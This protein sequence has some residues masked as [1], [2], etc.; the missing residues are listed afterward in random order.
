ME[1]MLI[2]DVETTN[3][4][5]DALIYDLGFAVIDQ[6]GKI[7][8]GGSY[9]VADIFLNDELM[10]EAYFA[11]KIPQYK[12]DLRN[13]KRIMRR[14]KTLKFIMRDIIKQ[15]EITKI[16]AYNVRFDWNAILT[17]ERYLTKSKYRYFLP[18][19]CYPLDILKMARKKY[20]DDEKYL[21]FCKEN[22]YMITENRARFTAEVMYKF[23][24]GDNNFTESHTGFEDVQIEKEIFINCLDFFEVAPLWLPLIEGDQGARANS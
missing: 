7:F 5:D 16:L 23:L 13:G 15:Y 14:W 3:S 4:L 12:E 2:L 20:K 9:V 22:G 18:F 17:T 10:K 6:T 21:S 11:D 8:E 1:K 19:G 24:T